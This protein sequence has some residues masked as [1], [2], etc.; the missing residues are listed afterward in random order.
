MR[1]TA[2]AREL[3]DAEP[4]LADRG[5]FSLFRIAGIHIRVQPSWFFIFFLVLLTLSTGHY[6]AAAPG[7]GFASYWLAGLLTTLLFFVSL[8]I[9]ELAH[10][11]MA[12]RAGLEVPRITLFLFGGVSEIQREPPTPAI[13]FRI[14]VLGPLTSFALGAFFWFASTLLPAEPWYL[15]AVARYLGWI[16]LALG[17]FNLLPGYPLDGG[18]VLR[19]FLWKKT[20]SL[21]RATRAASIAGKSF[22]VALM[23]LGGIEILLGGLMGGIWLIL[24]GLFLRSLA[25]QSYQS[26]LLRRM[27]EDGS[28]EDVMTPAGRLVRVD[29]DVSLRELVDDYFL[30]HGYRGFPVTRDGELLGLITLEGV[31]QRE[32]STWEGTS[33]REAMVPLSAETSIG[34]HT[35]LTEAVKK[36]AASPAGRLLVV[37]DGE[38]AG[39][40]STADLTRFLD[41]KSLIAP[42][43]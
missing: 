15:A 22:G 43:R 21:Q 28:V 39:W 3:D 29:P 4:V 12:L 2:S 19:A 1:A 5:G 40:I 30:K 34:V 10:A 14:A 41:L 18:R 8:L 17:A 20:G 42:E 27:L 26:L 33:V 31:R 9:H 25:G 35:P 38:L 16:N 6:P 13:E 37:E 11:W 32:R 23:V 7:Q 24:I 36:I